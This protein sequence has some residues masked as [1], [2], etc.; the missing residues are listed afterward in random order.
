MTKLNT[1]SRYGALA[2]LAAVPMFAAGDPFTSAGTSISAVVLSFVTI[3]I[4]AVI[5]FKVLGSGMS[6]G[7]KLVAALGEGALLAFAVTHSQA[8]VN[9]IQSI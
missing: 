4:G 1:I 6:M 5:A 2:I 7:G 3:V 8:I 9:W